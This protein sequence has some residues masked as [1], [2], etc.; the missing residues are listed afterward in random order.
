MSSQASNNVVER[1]R[2]WSG[3]EKAGECIL[4]SSLLLQRTQLQCP[5][6]SGN[7]QHCQPRWGKFHLWFSDIIFPLPTPCYG[8]WKLPVFHENTVPTRQQLLQ[9]SLLNRKETDYEQGLNH[10]DVSECV[11]LLQRPGNSQESHHSLASS[12]LAR[13]TTRAHP[14]VFS[15]SNTRFSTA[16]S[17]PLESGFILIFPWVTCT[18]QH[19]IC[20]PTQ[21]NANTF[22][23]LYH[24]ARH[25]DGS[26]RQDTRLGPVFTVYISDDIYQL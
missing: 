21:Q 18:L 20:L 9:T 25:S 4:R 8:R 12:R 2:V 24:P 7:L 15:T 14:A 10:A 19:I 5:A 22:S 1:S 23:C 13:P 17:K 6:S 16:Q 11:A 26:G 3:T